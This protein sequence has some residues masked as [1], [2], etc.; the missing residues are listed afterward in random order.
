MLR[1]LH[2][3][4]AEALGSCLLG[5]FCPAKYLDRDRHVKPV[6]VAAGEFEKHVACWMGWPDSEDTRY[7]W[8]EGGAPAQEQYA[9]IATAI[10]QF[11]PLI[12]LANPGQVKN[13]A[14]CASWW[15]MWGS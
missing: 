5:T 15:C 3:R 13:R 10:S 8:R 6:P 4:S 9:D 11:E 2:L 14:A 12:M 1:H 7:L